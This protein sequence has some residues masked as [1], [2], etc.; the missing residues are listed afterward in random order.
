[1]KKDIAKKQTTIPDYILESIKKTGGREGLENITIED[2]AIPRIELIQA[3][4]PARIKSDPAYIE[5]ADEGQLFNSV[6][7]ELYRRR[8]FRKFRFRS[9]SGIGN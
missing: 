7:R 3:L 6:T 9:G 4:S 2:I 8:V 1:M 5:G